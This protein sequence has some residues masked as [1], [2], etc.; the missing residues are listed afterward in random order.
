MESSPRVWQAR[1][2]LGTQA[3]V[4]V[5][6]PAVSAVSL[7]T[8]SLSPGRQAHM[9][10]VL[11]CSLSPVILALA[12]LGSSEPALFHFLPTLSGFTHIYVFVY[13]P[14]A[15]LRS[16][17]PEGAQQV[18]PWG[19]GAWGIFHHPSRGKSI[20]GGF[21]TL[22][23]KAHGNGPG[24]HSGN[25]H[26]RPFFCL[27]CPV[28]SYSAPWNHLRSELPSPKFLLQVMLLGEPKLRKPFFF[29]SL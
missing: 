15:L 10:P 9:G 24:V 14:R 17:M 20:L 18:H 16:G 7:P 6:L 4:S 21:C 3:P 5:L 29:N 19:R 13:C 28:S 12:G 8:A 27:Y 23:G 2:G 11:R 25:P 1:H 22:L 26:Y